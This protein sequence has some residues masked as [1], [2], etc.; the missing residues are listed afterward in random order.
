MIAPNMIWALKTDGRW[1]LDWTDVTLDDQP[2]DGSVA[3][4]RADVTDAMV[5]RAQ[6][7]LFDTGL[8]IDPDRVRAALEAAI[9]VSRETRP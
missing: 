2:H 9:M 4:I 8:F 3:Y 1:D 6:A 5:A 7:Y